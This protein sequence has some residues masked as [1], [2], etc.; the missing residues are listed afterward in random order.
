[1]SKRL[2]LYC[3]ADETGPD[4]KGAMFL[5]AVVI[6]NKEHRETTERDL[7][8]LE[9]D[10]GKKL[11]KWKSTNTQRKEAYLQGVLEIDSLQGCLFYALYKDTTDY[12]NLTALTIA[13]AV[14]AFTQGR[15]YRATIYIDGLPKN[16][17]S[18]VA[19]FLSNRGIKRRKIRGLRDESSAYIRLADALAGFFRDY[20][21]TKPYTK[22]LF[23]RFLSRN[24]VKKLA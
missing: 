5:V 24:Y 8:Q 7:E 22:R 16:Q 15:D 11:L 4:T 14:N 1:L 13:K 20:E 6:I 9:V 23:Q 2:G 21:E 18:K 3:Y 10:S 19:R 12:L 17:I